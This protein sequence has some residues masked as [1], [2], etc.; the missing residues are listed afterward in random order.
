MFKNNILHHTDA[1]MY[2]SIV[3]SGLVVYK[4]GLLRYWYDLSQTPEP[5]AVWNFV[6][7]MDWL[8]LTSVWIT[9]PFD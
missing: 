3:L 2:D 4:V 1:I 9:R 7:W 8:Y 6:T 5:V